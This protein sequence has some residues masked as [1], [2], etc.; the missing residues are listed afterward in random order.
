M[1]LD[2]SSSFVTL[3]SPIKSS[4][5]KKD[6]KSIKLS[7][8]LNVLL[9]S[10]TSY[11]LIKLDK[12]E[13]IADEQK[14]KNSDFNEAFTRE[15][16]KKRFQRTISVEDSDLNAKPPKKQFRKSFERD[17]LA[18]DGTILN[19]DETP[20]SSDLEGYKIRL[21]RTI[22][23]EDYDIDVKLQKKTF[24]KW[25]QKT[26][27]VEQEILPEDDNT[28]S[29]LKE[30]AAAL[31]IGAGSYSDPTD[32]QG[33]AHFLEHM[34]FMGSEKYPNENAF[35]EFIKNHGGYNNASTSGENTTFYFNVQRKH[36]KEAFDRFTQ[37]FIAPLLKKEAMQKERE[38]VD[39]EFQMG[40]TSDVRKT[41]QL[42]RSLANDN[43]PMKKFGCGNL[44][45]LKPTE[46]D[47]DQ[48][49]EQLKD[50][51][52]R[53]YSAASMTL[54]VQSQHTLEDLE[55]LVVSSCSKIK[56]NNQGR[57]KET[58]RHLGAP[59]ADVSKF[60]RIYKVLPIEDTYE[61][62][63]NW[64]L[65][66][67]LG[68]YRTKPLFYLSRIINHKG[69]GSL[70]SYLR[71]K[72]WALGLSSG[73]SSTATHSIFTISILLTQNGHVNVE[74]VLHGVFSYLSMLRQKGPNQRLFN[75]CKKILELEFEYE[76]ERESVGDVE[77]L[78]K[79]MHRYP[80][81]QYV[82][83]WLLY[84]FD[85]QLINRMLQKLTAEE[86]NI[87][88]CSKEYKE[89]AIKVEPIYKTNYIDEDI[90]PKWRESWI[91]CS[92]ISAF[93]LPEPNMF[94]AQ[95]LS[96]LPPP[97]SVDIL[98][99]KY[100]IKIKKD[101]WGE[102][103]FRQDTTFKQPRF[104]AAFNLS[105]GK[106]WK[107]A[108]NIICKNILE[109][110]ICQRM[111]EDVYPAIQAFLGYNVS[112]CS[113]GSI[114]IQISGLNH[115]LP[116]LLETILK[117]ISETHQNLEES[118][119][120]A[121]QNQTKKDYFNIMIDPSMLASDLQMNVLYKSDVTYME[122][123][124][125]VNTITFETLKVFAKEFFHSFSFVRGLVQG[126]VSE[127]QACK[128]YNTAK[129]VLIKE[130]TMLLG[131]KDVTDKEYNKLPDKEVYLRVSGVNPTDSNTVVQNYYQSEDKFCLTTLIP[132]AVGLE[133]M[134]EPVFN[135]LRTKEQLG[136]SVGASLSNTGGIL[137]VCI[138]V[139]SQATKFTADYIHD[140]IEAFVKWFIEEK[141]EL[142]SD[143]EF[144]D[145]ID[146][147]IKKTKSADITLGE[148]F[149]R[150]WDRIISKDYMFDFLEEQAK[151]LKTCTKQ[152]VIRS[153]S[154]TI[155]RS[156]NRKKF[157][158]QVVGCSNETNGK[159]EE[160][161]TKDEP[162]Q[163]DLLLEAEGALELDYL[164]LEDTGMAPH[165]IKDIGA[166]RNSLEAFPI[167]R[168]SK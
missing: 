88:M 11:N 37:F 66:Q 151:L 40:M 33:L 52:F 156:Q 17:F 168:L 21:R 28:S 72:T 24:R 120:D 112:L 65:P 157:S 108:E 106:K 99:S 55:K 154:S 49:H 102:L 20:A 73:G 144:N 70:Y 93:Y 86:V 41:N 31:C 4:S 26:F 75:E 90:P 121:I 159:E 98:S 14:E 101:M 67:L 15:G 105:S 138:K 7:N 61:V 46:L 76:E 63:L 71:H 69:K 50:F 2:M 38:I 152:D 23:V 48:I 13:S 142:L 27:E 160:K 141:M 89:I 68:E 153:I 146:T 87:F 109:D 77:N 128:L 143:N 74:H 78:S 139:T 115:K 96:L 104:I 57:E 82:S 116:L 79:V 132:L 137:G 100:P 45:T 34:V 18:Q 166:F 124:Q 165:F 10:D 62:E 111:I 92:P 60:S 91:N 134:Q 42:F 130:S 80:A 35:D 16:Y 1:S 145:I 122:L 32:L 94:I 97:T 47:D 81:E 8:G 119:F 127:D 22:S 5:N 136:Y 118:M 30:S 54:V 103:Y 162:N 147:V 44:T 95:N 167:V 56:N 135:I 158:V 149:L 140:R 125:T 9:I 113:D 3:P 51:F 84:E 114:T 6:Y 163:H 29:G 36:F 39:S 85:Y 155:S 164:T 126:N 129:S 107:S 148:E 131:D 25:F 58:F 19:D 59:F 123:H 161:E 43:H 110:M 133:L 64:A 150:N 83:W 117:N 53:H 12:E